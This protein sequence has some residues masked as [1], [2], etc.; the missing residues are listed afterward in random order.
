MSKS[1]ISNEIATRYHIMPGCD[2]GIWFVIDRQ[3]DIAILRF[4]SRKECEEW[5]AGVSTNVE[6]E[7][8]ALLQPMLRKTDKYLWQQI[9]NLLAA[10]KDG[11][12]RTY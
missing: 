8:T 2:H 11:I 9:N 4:Y 5:I 12:E 1:E 7:A 3:T 6:D 10:I